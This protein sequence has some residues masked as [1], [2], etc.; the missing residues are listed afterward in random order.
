MKKTGRPKKD[1]VKANKN[2]VNLDSL[3][4]SD[5]EEYTKEEIK[6]LKEELLR[7]R[8][9]EEFSKKIRG[10]SPRL[11]K[12]ENQQIKAQLVLELRPKYQF[13]MLLEEA[14]M[15]RGS[16]LYQLRKAPSKC[17]DAVYSEQIAAIR[18]IHSDSKERY[19]YRRVMYALHNQGMHLNHK[20][21]H[22]MM[23]ICSF[24]EP[25]LEHIRNTTLT[26][27]LLG[28]LLQTSLT[29]NSILLSQ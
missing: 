25:I 23:I 10:L 3:L 11:S 28:R 18:K 15:S 7:L 9:H 17:L 16:Y 1:E 19:G 4:S 8:C 29:E 12:K 2:K 20:T 26:K 6:A 13:K 5:K 14:Q 27:V 21:V 24:R 22:K